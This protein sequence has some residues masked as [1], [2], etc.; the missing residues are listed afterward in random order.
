MAATSPNRQMLRFARMSASM[1]V[2]KIA[3]NSTKNF[4]D[5]A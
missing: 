5:Y 3:G 2:T 4:L 1:T